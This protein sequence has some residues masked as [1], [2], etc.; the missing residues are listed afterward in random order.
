MTR[1]FQELAHP[2]DID[3]IFGKTKHPLT[4]AKG[5][6]IGGGTVYPELNFTLP[7]I[8]ICDENFAQIKDMYKN[9]IIDACRRAMELQ[10]P[11]LCIEFETLIEMT[12]VPNYAIDLTG[13][14]AEQLDHFFNHHQLPSTLR[15]TP[16]DTR[17]KTRPPRMRD[18]EL[19]DSMFETFTGCAKNGAE[20]LS[21]ESTGGKEIHDD[22]LLMCDL[23]SVIFSLAVL[24]VRDMAFLWNRISAIARETGTI[25]AGDTACGF[26]NTAMVLAEKKFIPRVFSALV[27]A[28]TIPRSLVA[29]EQGA[30]G[31]GKDCGYENPFLKAITGFPMSME[32][33]SAA[34]AHASP[35]GNISSAFCDLWSNESV[36][37][38]KLL[39][40]MAPTVFLESLAYDCR[41][42]N[43]ASNGKALMLRDLMVE[44]DAP[45]DPQAFILSPQNVLAISESLVEAEGHYAQTVSSVKTALALIHQ[46]HVEGELK[47]SENEIGWFDNYFSV[48]DK[49]PS[50]EDQFIDLIMA[51]VDHSKFNANDYDLK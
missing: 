39:G 9:I 28:A 32:G 6:V 30:V 4:T 12:L 13:I 34:C 10:V 2:N 36:Q 15:I 38:I 1:S 48:L 43:Q 29:Y 17:D 21:I 8:K 26:G 19:V 22:A 45:L 44:S 42:M 5:L 33:K 7:P 51:K 35:L 24:G 41:L 47:V 27:R 23:E 40:G 14:I 16:N 25:A 18:G 49:M 11:G 37:N 50:S 20:L 31:P 46:A 3:L